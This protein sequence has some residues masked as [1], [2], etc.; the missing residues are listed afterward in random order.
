MTRQR[1]AADQQDEIPASAPSH[2]R[3][4]EII[5]KSIQVEALK[6]RIGLAAA[7][8]LDILITG[9]SGTGKELVARA[10]SR[11]GRRRQGK[12]IP[13]DCGSLSDSLAEAELFGY[14][15][16]A[17]T[18]A[19][20]NRQ[21][22]LEAADGGIIFLDE[23][24]N[25]PLR[26]QAKLLRVLQEREVR[27]IGETA[28]R[29]LDVQVIAATNKDLLGDMKSDQFRGDLYY[30]LKAM[31]IRLPSLRER[32]EDIPLLIEWFLE[33]TSEIEGG[34]KKKI[35]PET[36]Q[37]LLDYSYPGNIRELKNIVASAYYSSPGS[38][39]GRAVL[40]PEVF[41][42][43][44]EEI[45]SDASI[46]EKIYREIL[47]GKGGFDDLIKAPFLKHQ[48]GISVLKEVIQKALLDT[49]GVYRAALKRLGVAHQSYSVTIQF[50]KRHCCYLD[51]RQFRHKVSNPDL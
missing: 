38:V 24:S 19:V 25:M 10:I 18:G 13:I 5:G 49:N 4:P 20:E 34:R 15:K 39:I 23:I 21:G 28:P 32:A 2:D 33:K 36:M 44:T 29:K 26:L 45:F 6:E 51:F 22:L 17:F 50:L 47:E 31:E 48:F 11:T 16:G 35:V 12:F 3:Y 14:R 41:H 27:R 8:P 7:S 46:A 40:P 1:L 42:K 9:E 43:D 30:R 37:I